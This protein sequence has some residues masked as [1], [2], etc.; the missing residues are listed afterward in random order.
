MA[1]DDSHGRTQPG[2]LDEITLRR[3][4]RGDEDACRALVVCYQRAVFALLGRMLGPGRQGLVEDLAQDTFLQVF[5]ALASFAPLGPAKL[6]TWIL[7]IASRRA[8][9]ALRK[10]P[11]VTEPLE[12]ETMDAPGG[13]RGDDAMRRR[14]VAAAIERA[15]ADLGPAYRAAFLLREYHDLDY[16]EIA[17]ALDIDLGTVKSRLARARAALRQALEEV[18]DG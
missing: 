16:G 15:L 14:Q 18:R 17:R 8:V 3:A 5:R 6:S 12:P 2:E 1:P 7:T 9:D 13:E 4:Q 11:P 10:H